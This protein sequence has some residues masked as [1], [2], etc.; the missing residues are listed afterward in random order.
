MRKTGIRQLSAAVAALAIGGAS[1][2]AAQ[3]KSDWEF[4]LAPMYIWGQSVKGTSYIGP[5]GGDLEIDFIDDVL[6]NL[7]TAATVHFEA[8]NDDLTYFI[9]LNHVSLD[10]ESEV[11]DVIS[12]SIDYEMNMAEIGVTWAFAEKP[13]S[14][15]WEAMLGRR[16]IEQDIKVK[17]DIDLP[18]PIGRSNTV[19][20]GDDWY[21]PFL[22]VRVFQPLSERWGMIGRFDYGYSDSDNKAANA[23]ITFD[24]RFN[25]WGSLLLG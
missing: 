17:A 15:R 16:Y 12:A 7:N 19:N 18:P 13:Q 2:P 5:A 24:W 21:H 20:G 1:L 14:R 25:N 9:D 23:Q 22:G 6:D 8:V 4:R 11:N 3:A 10:P